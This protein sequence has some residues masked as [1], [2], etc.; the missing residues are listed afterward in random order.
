MRHINGW[1]NGEGTFLCRIVL[2]VNDIIDDGKR[3]WNIQGVNAFRE[4][5]GH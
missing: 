1:R 3:R 5:C 2:E 4:V